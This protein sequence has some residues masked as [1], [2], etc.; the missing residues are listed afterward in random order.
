ML[1]IA[2]NTKRSEKVPFRLILHATL[3]EIPSYIT[4][5]QNER[6]RIILL[7]KRFA[8]KCENYTVL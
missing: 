2:C 5:I 7:K 8:F 1:S 3:S 4:A 6:L